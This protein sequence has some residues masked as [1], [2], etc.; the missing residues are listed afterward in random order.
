M[1]AIKQSS[2][3]NLTDI[4]SGIYTCC[5]LIQRLILITGRSKDWWWPVIMASGDCIIMKCCKL[6]III[7]ILSRGNLFFM[8]KILV[9]VSLDMQPCV[10]GFL[11]TCLNFD[12]SKRDCD[13]LLSYCYRTRLRNGKF[14]YYLRG[15]VIWRETS[16]RRN[17]RILA[18]CH[19]VVVGDKRV[20]IKCFTFENLKKHCYLIQKMSVRFDLASNNY[21]TY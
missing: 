11:N 8:H 12:I 7:I 16:L 9:N 4:G 2:N 20:K 5:S 15:K 13:V 6:C 17:Q 14:N 1:S 10:F 19:C 18:W 21:Y 3:L